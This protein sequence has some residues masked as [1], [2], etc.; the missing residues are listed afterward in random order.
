MSQH[1]EIMKKLNNSLQDYIKSCSNIEE[2]INDL[3]VSFN[4]FFLKR[5]ID[6]ENLLKLI[7][8]SEMNKNNSFYLVNVEIV[9]KIKKLYS[10]DF[11]SNKALYDEDINIIN[12]EV[13]STC[14][15]EV[16]K[17]AFGETVFEYLTD[18]LFNGEELDIFI[19]ENGVEKTRIIKTVYEIT[20]F[21]TSLDC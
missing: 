4:S 15:A 11:S 14:M 2:R 8:K 21:L 7:K 9:K 13:F 20:E 17:I 19:V 12:L 10:L 3:G 5:Q 1:F 6:I 16:L 18:Y